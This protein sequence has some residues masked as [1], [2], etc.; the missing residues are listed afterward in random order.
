MPEYRPRAERASVSCCCNSGTVSECSHPGEL[1]FL[2][3]RDNKHSI[4][5]ATRENSLWPEVVLSPAIPITGS[6][7]AE[8]K[9]LTVALGTRGNFKR[10]SIPS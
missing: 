7:A 2:R 8:E 10:R 1:C 4:S 5:S 6:E 3:E 9:S